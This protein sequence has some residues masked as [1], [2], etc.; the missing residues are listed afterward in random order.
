VQGAQQLGIGG[1][2]RGRRGVGSRLVQAGRS[3]ARGGR[4][5]A[6]CASA[7]RARLDG[8]GRLLGAWR[9]QARVSWREKRDERRESIGEG[10]R[11]HS[12]DGLEMGVRRARA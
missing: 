2:G 12:G 6:A 5:S 4:G 11:K 9:L 7:S 8:R 1:V 3:G 10:D